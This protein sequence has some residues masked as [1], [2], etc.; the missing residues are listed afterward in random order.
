VTD[1]RARVGSLELVSP[2]IAAAGT[3]GYGL[4]YDGLVD[5]AKVG[6]ICVKGLSCKPWEGHPAPRMLETP[7]GMLNAIGLQNI[8]VDAFARDKLP[9]LREIRAK[10]PKIV[11]N[12]W[13]DVP[14][15]Y[16]RVVGM[17]DALDGVDAIE[18]NLAC[19][20]KG[21]TDCIPA[22]DPAK[23]AEIVRLVRPHTSGPLW[24]KLT[25]NVTD[26]A[27]VARAVEDAGADAISLVN[28]LKAMAVDARTRRP[29]LTNITGGLSGPAIKPIALYMVWEVSRAVRVPVIG[30]GGVV[31][32]EDLVEFLEVG[33]SAVQIGTANLY[34]PAAPA[35]ITG[36]V[37]ALL[38][39]MGESAVADL[40]GSLELD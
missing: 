14:D 13:A 2:V 25:P 3:Y 38:E 12:C 24:V 1:L 18:L 37:A 32:G 19:P 10:G 5:W 11:A 34:D 15:E 40:I 9:A 16:E 20:N 27:A 22:A 36:E 7:A 29:L 17:L 8:G 30:G 39:S 23:A 33:A 26:V 35:R 28:T 21:D 6:A 4:E 31:S